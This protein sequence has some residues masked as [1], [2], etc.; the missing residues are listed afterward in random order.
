MGQSN[1]CTL[2]LKELYNSTHL[3]PELQEMGIFTAAAPECLDPGVKPLIFLQITTMDKGVNKH[4]H[5][6]AFY[7]FKGYMWIT[8]WNCCFT[9][10]EALMGEWGWPGFHAPSHAEEQ[11][12]PHKQPK[13]FW[14]YLAQ[15]S[16]G[17][18]N[19]PTYSHSFP[20]TFVQPS[21]Q[22]RLKRTWL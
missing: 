14:G 9:G 1:I 13:S 20:C 5:I 11:E 10:R 8:V 17:K 7:H 22:N 6:T 16:M 2:L 4:S 19:I 3:T 15:C 12:A 18:L 21:E